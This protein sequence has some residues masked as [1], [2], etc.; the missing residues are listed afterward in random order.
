MGLEPACEL[1]ADGVHASYFD[2][3]HINGGFTEIHG[4]PPHILSIFA[5]WRRAHEIHRPGDSLIWRRKAGQ[6]SA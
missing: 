2:T 4:D 6:R 3:R 5:Q 1:F